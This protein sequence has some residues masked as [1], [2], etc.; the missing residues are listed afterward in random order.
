MQIKRNP[1]MMIYHIGWMIGGFTDYFSRSESKRRNYKRNIE[2]S[3]E[4]VSNPETSLKGLKSR[5][6]SLWLIMTPFIIFGVIL[7]TILGLSIPIFRLPGDWA[8][9]I[10]SFCFYFI[11]TA[12]V[13]SFRYSISV[14]D[15]KKFERLKNKKSLTEDFQVN[16]LAEPKFYDLLPGVLFAALF[17]LFLRSDFHTMI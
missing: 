10:F 13:I 4:Q 15:Y 9:P 16:H 3:K 5:T 8:A 7:Q 1:E 14:W 12:L 2:I 11:S 6:E 17:Y